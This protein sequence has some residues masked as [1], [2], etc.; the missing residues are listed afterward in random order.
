MSKNRISKKIFKALLI[1]TLACN[2]ILGCACANEPTASSATNSWIVQSG[3]PIKSDGE[4]GFMYLNQDNYDI[5][6]KSD[7]TWSK[8]GNIKGTSGNTPE[9]TINND[10]YW[11]INNVPTT[12]KAKGE[13]GNTPNITINDE[14]YWT[15]DGT[16]TTVKAK[17]EDGNMPNITIND[18]G[19]WVVNDTPTTVKA[20]GEDGKTPSV[21]INDDG[22]WVVNDVAT[23]Y[24]AGQYIESESPAVTEEKLSKEEFYSQVVSYGSCNVPSA[25]S[26]ARISFSVKMKAGTTFTF[27][28]DT[29]VYEWAVPEIYE[30]G[31]TEISTQETRPTDSVADSG[32][33]SGT[34]YTTKQD[35]WPMP[36]VKRLDGAELTNKDLMTIQDMFTVDG[37]KVTPTT[38][39]DAG[40][41]TQ[42][43]YNAQVVQLGTVSGPSTIFMRMTFAI[44]MDKGVKVTF[45]GDNTVYNWQVYEIF[46]SA[47]NSYYYDGGFNVAPVTE[48]TSVMDGSYLVLQVARIDAAN[49]T[50]DEI[51]SMHDMFTVTGTKWTG[52]K[53]VEQVDYLVNSVNHRG[54]SLQAPEN[55]LSA[56]RLSALNG[57]TKVEADI[58]FTKD[59]HAVL[60]HDDTIDRTSNGTGA[61]NELTLEQVRQY[62]FGSW[63]SPE[64]KGEKIPTFEEFLLLCKSLNLHPYIELKAS[65]DNADYIASL[66]KT[67]KSYGM[68]DN[69]SW[70][71]FYST[72]LEKVID[73]DPTARVGFLGGDVN[74]ATINIVTSLRTRSNNQANI[75]LDS[76]NAS[77]TVSGVNLCI[78]NNVPLEVW[79][80]NSSAV[81]PTLHPYISGITSDVLI[82]GQVMRENALK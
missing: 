65:T 48:Y 20:K 13:D 24:H 27:T 19:Y 77:L 31:I 61:I 52:Q 18:D 10:G 23:N 4:D 49:L 55:T 50:Y 7:G 30:Q 12:V 72:A 80:V 41:L 64:Y 28:G 44:K 16:P 22:Y 2:L 38:A 57:F 78:E 46:H 53:T 62:D 59:G 37:V 36:T 82:A 43:E 42:E 68:I 15:I 3:A 11:V 45:V 34:T 6:F 39:D 67:V 17:G 35:C 40:Q 58:S 70:I 5:Y 14:G 29:S 69:V 71:S 33:I 73:N 81:I 47:Q 54:Y 63:K 74:S 75:F 51:A 79:T 56:Y 66:V 8:V 1:G 76:S 32:W 9:I 26:R 60:L 25:K 21:Y